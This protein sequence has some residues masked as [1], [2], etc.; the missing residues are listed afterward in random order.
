MEIHLLN[1]NG[2]FQFLINQFK[3]ENLT[4]III[5]LDLPNPKI[6]NNSFHFGL[7]LCW[8]EGFGELGIFDLLS[9]GFEHFDSKDNRTSANSNKILRF[10]MRISIRQSEVKEK[11][12]RYF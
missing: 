1:T 11:A 12:R 6:L 2:T 4:K 3:L 5:P 10:F 7:K 9:A 8:P